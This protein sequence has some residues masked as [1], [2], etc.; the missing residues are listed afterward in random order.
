M[1]LKFALL[2]VA[3]SIFASAAP[4]RFAGSWAWTGAQGAAFQ[5]T[6]HEDGEKISGD[7]TGT[8]LRGN[9][10]SIGAVSGTIS[11]NSARLQWSFKDGD[12][13]GPVAGTA[14][15]DRV[16]AALRW[17]LNYDGT[18]DC[19]FPRAVVLKRKLK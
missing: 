10:V 7:M 13:A 17:K 15:L 5:I 3:A 18:E 12:Q 1:K 16:N 6:L 19:W 2:L 11:G 4:L 9:R 14:T 8:A